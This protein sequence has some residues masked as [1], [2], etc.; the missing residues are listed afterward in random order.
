VP[1]PTLFCLFD[2]RFAVSDV[3]RP[4]P[5]EYRTVTLY[6]RIRTLR[7]FGQYGNTENWKL[8]RIEFLEI[9]RVFSQFNMDT[10]HTKIY[11]SCR[12]EFRK[13]GKISTSYLSKSWSQDAKICFGPQSF[14]SSSF[15]INFTILTL[16]LERG[17]MIVEIVSPQKPH[18]EFRISPPGLAIHLFRPFSTKPQPDLSARLCGPR[19]SS[20]ANALPPPHF[21]ARSISA[22]RSRTCRA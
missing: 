17:E 13:N 10:T 2:V 4:T 22:S 18:L 19:L 7:I 16:K 3:H 14:M 15:F 12:P 8:N 21:F 9:F 20:V 1:K 11:A 6:Y 5:K